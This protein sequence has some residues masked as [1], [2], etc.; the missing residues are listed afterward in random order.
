VSA[1]R[2]GAQLD[3]FMLPAARAEERGLQW[4]V[5]AGLLFVH[6]FPGFMNLNKSS[7]ARRNT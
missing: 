4:Q 1:A 3:L 2:R 5:T 7:M 6:A